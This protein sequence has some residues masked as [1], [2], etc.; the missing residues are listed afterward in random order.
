ML[1]YTR[2]WSSRE[3]NT[4]GPASLLRVCVHVCLFGAVFS[5][6][7][8]LLGDIYV[9][10]KWSLVKHSAT[11]TCFA[12]H[13]PFVV[14]TAPIISPCRGWWWCGFLPDARAAISGNVTS[15]NQN[16]F[17]FVRIFA[18]GRAFARAG[19]VGVCAEWKHRW[20]AW[21]KQGRAVGGWCQ[22][23]TPT[24]RLDAL[25]DSWESAGNSPTGKV[26][27]SIGPLLRIALNS[28]RQGNPP[29]APH[30]THTCALVSQVEP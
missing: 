18:S 15:M 27:A 16:M 4:F 23:L 9:P 2:W 12:T 14:A 3:R 19:R 24:T 7:A 21:H 25:S 1:I 30:L 17:V 8:A 10:F 20:D 13:R 29:F 6:E 22:G 28:Q 11:I 5:V 26:S